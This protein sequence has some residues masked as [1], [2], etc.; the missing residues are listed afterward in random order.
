MAK[1][2]SALILYK[3]NAFNNDFEYIAEYYSIKEIQAKRPELIKKNIN[4]L[5][6]GIAKS[7]DAITY[8]IGD[9]YAIIKEELTD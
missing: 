8:L 5:Y 2:K 9:K 3:Y 4:S 6:H 7:I 1:N